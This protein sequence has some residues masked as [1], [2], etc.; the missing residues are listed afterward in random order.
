MSEKAV[1]WIL[2][3]V[4]VAVFLAICIPQFIKYNKDAKQKE[5]EEKEIRERTL[6]KLKKEEEEEL[7]RTVIWNGFFYRKKGETLMDFARR[8][9]DTEMKEKYEEA[10]CIQACEAIP[11]SP[12][13]AV[14]IKKPKRSVQLCIID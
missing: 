4:V 6:E 3:V 5:E 2:I 7:T 9:F 8:F 1:T 12:H 10:E 14:W 13:C 11:G